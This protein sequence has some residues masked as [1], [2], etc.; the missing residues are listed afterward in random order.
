MTQPRRQLSKPVE[1]CEVLLGPAGGRA[2]LG[3]DRLERVVL[4]GQP[5]TDGGLDLMA[6]A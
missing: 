5:V 1:Q 6:A 2:A 3:E 4:I